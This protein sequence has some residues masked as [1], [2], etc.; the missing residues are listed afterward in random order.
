MLNTSLTLEWL[1]LLWLFDWASSVSLYL[2]QQKK[3]IMETLPCLVVVVVLRACYYL[4]INAFFNER[5]N[6]ILC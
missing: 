1:S 3:Y 4:T 5:S 2:G 6:G